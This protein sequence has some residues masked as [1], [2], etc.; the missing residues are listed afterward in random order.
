MRE[1]GAFLT[2]L[3]LAEETMQDRLRLFVYHSNQKRL[4]EAKLKEVK[5]EADALEAK[6]LKDFEDSGT[7]KVRVDGV[8]VYLH[9]QLWAGAVDGDKEAACAAIKAA[10]FAEYVSESFNAQSFSALV[11]EW[12]KQGEPMPPEFEGKIKVSEVF[13]IRTRRS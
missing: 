3:G 1:D 6:L 8:T 10:G 11:R 4:L 7:D 2:S 13:Q 9:R 12:D 5:A